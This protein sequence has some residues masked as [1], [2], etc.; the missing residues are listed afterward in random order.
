MLVAVAF[1]AQTRIYNFQ[2]LPLTDSVR[3]TFTVLQGSVCAGWE[4]WKGS[5]SINLNPIYAYP[6]LCGDVNFSIKYNYT[7]F[8]PNKVTPN[9]YQV[10]IPPNDYSPVLRV[11]IASSFSNLLVYPQP[12]EDY[13]NIAISQ[14]K[15]YNFEIHIFDRFGTKRGFGSGSAAERITLNVNSLIEGVYPFYIVLGDGSLYRGKFAKTPSN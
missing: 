11:D 7:D 15:N 10:R 6:G 2:V 4:I 1:N 14:R 3:L 5:D 8:S 9:F 12:V 13:L